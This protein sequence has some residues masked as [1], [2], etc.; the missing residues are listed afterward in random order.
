MDASGVAV[1][2]WFTTCVSTTGAA[3]VVLQADNTR[4]VAAAMKTNVRTNLDISSLLLFGYIIYKYV[5]SHLLI[6]M[7]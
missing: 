4:L 1:T 5:I 3:G 6:S 7:E 2:T